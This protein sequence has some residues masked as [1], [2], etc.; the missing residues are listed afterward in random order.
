MTGWSFCGPWS[1]CVCGLRH[2][3]QRIELTEKILQVYLDAW[4]Y[5]A[6][7]LPLTASSDNSAVASFA[8]N[9]T[10]DEFVRFVNDLA[11]AVDAFN[12][13]PGSPEWDRAEEILARVVELE[14]AFW[15]QEGEE[16]FELA[17]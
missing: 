10:N 11:D 13:Q 5:V 16:A 12:V 14:E 6:S 1:K 7:R 4:R 9:W 8:E 2:F 15:P 17:T 3:E